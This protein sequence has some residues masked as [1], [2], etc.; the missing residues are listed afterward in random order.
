MLNVESIQILATVDGKVGMIFSY[1]DTQPA[2]QFLFTLEKC[3]DLMDGLDR[4]Y[5]LARRQKEE[6]Q[7]SGFKD[8]LGLQ[9]DVHMEI[10]S[11]DDETEVGG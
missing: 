3:R 1:S 11:D 10:T 4:A 8:G 5:L 6:S 2:Q 9:E 7:Y